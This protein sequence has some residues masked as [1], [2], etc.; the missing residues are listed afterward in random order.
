M[1]REKP[2]P[3]AGLQQRL[4]L[5]KKQKWSQLPKAWHCLHILFFYIITVFWFKGLF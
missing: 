3:H 2:N 1:Y 5:A 4:N